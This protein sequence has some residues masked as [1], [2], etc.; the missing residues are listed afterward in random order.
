MREVAYHMADFLAKSGQYR[1]SSNTPKCSRAWRES[2]STC[3]RSAAPLSDPDPAIGYP[4]GN[5]IA[6]AALARGLNGVVY[7]SVRHAGGTCL[8]A[9]RPH[10]VQ[11]VAP[12]ASIDSNG[13]ASRSRR[14]RAFP[15]DFRKPRP[16]KLRTETP[17]GRPRYRR[18]GNSL[19]STACSFAPILRL[20]S[21]ASNCA[22]TASV[23]SSR[24]SGTLRVAPR[25]AVPLDHGLERALEPLAVALGGENVADP[26]VRRRSATRRR[27]TSSAAPHR[28]SAGRQRA[29]A[30][31]AVDRRMMLLRLV[32]WLRPEIAPIPNGRRKAPSPAQRRRIPSNR[33]RGPRNPPACPRTP[34][35]AR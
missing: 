11:S 20:N 16:F 29:M 25:R 12:A 9:L 35:N 15:S 13:P 2:S 10:A 32:A 24:G 21:S 3:R 34:S 14:S 18:G 5:A 22:L 33:P 19:A 30:A 28:R 4:I 1:A 23:L 27:K 7:P 8:A 31:S 6:D 17:T 26:D